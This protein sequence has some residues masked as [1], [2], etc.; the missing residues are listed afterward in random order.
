MRYRTAGD[1]F[2]FDNDLTIRVADTGNWRY[3]LLVGIHELIE[4]FLCTN[5][6]ITQEI[7]DEFDM[8][9]Q[10]D[11]DPGSH[12]DSPYQGPHIT[13]FGIEM[14]LAAALGVKWRLYEKCLE[15]TIRKTPL[16]ESQPQK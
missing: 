16:V 14:M 4:V 11:E 5:Q 9:H 13:A 15:K 7:V 6:G 10:R 8:S 12:F 2:F 3:N 1:W